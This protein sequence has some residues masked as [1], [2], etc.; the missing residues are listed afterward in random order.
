MF[1]YAQQ[2]KIIRF[3]DALPILYLLDPT[4]GVHIYEVG[5][6]SD[7]A[8]FFEI[9]LIGIING[10]RF[11][12]AQPSVL[13]VVV[14]RYAYGYAVEFQYD[15]KTHHYEISNVYWND[16]INTDVNIF[17]QYVILSG[18]SSHKIIL[19]SQNK[20]DNTLV[21][22]YYPKIFSTLQSNQQLNSSFHFKK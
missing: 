14:Q 21:Q 8:Q 2:V 3:T 17:N 4:T 5:I 22:N 10:F 7:S 18:V 11:D 20:A 12:E 13:I 19:H 9:M 1:G 6:L 16:G 15:I